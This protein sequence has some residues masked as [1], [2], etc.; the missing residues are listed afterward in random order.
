MYGIGQVGGR[1]ADI[2]PASILE[3][4]TFLQRVHLL[5]PDPELPGLRQ[6]DFRPHARTLHLRF[7]QTPAKTHSHV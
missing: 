3:R 7:E 6:L 4:T 2:E 1:R 5:P